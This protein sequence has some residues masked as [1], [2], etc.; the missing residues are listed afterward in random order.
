MGCC[1]RRLAELL[2]GQLHLHPQHACAGDLYRY[3]VNGTWV[4]SHR[5]LYTNDKKGHFTK[6]LWQRWDHASAAWVNELLTDYS[7]GRNGKIDHSSSQ[8]WDGARQV[9]SDDHVSRV[10]FSYDAAA[11]CTGNSNSIRISKRWIKNL[12]SIITYDAQ[13][14]KTAQT[15]Q[16]WD[17]KAK[18]G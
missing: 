14:H 17:Y 11:R 18:P 8:E 1:S 4:N 7:W 5:L 2:L 13:G 6:S 15:V 9:W 10:Q 3:W 16:V 12:N